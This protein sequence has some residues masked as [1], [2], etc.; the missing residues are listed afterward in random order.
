MD[1]KI[2]NEVTPGD[3]RN[4]SF[5]L[6]SH[7]STV[8]PPNYGPGGDRRNGSFPLTESGSPINPP[9]AG[10]RD[11]WGISAQMPENRPADKEGARLVNP[12]LGANPMPAWVMRG[13]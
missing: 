3:R 4:G 8:N 1:V 2:P 11:N 6:A 10:L 7:A 5:P 9:N 13:K 12:G